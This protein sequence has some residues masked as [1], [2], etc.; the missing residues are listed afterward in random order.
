MTRTSNR[1][2]ERK[3]PSPATCWKRLP[4]RPTSPEQHSPFRTARQGD[5]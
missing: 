3:S 1:N 5:D 4:I 2:L